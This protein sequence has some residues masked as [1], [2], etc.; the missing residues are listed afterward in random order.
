M[1][2]KDKDIMHISLLGALSQ[3]I[4]YGTTFG[5]TPLVAANLGA[6]SFQLGLLTM[7]FNLPQILFAALAGTVFVRYLGIRKT[8]LIG[9]GL[10]TVLSIGIPF[11][12]TLFTLYIVQIINGIGSAM[13]F[14]LLTGLVIKNVQSNLKNTVMGFYQS[15]YGV[16]MIIG[17]ILLGS[18]GDKWGLMTGFIIIGL[19]GLLAI[20]SLLLIDVESE[21]VKTS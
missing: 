2:I 7:L 14:P 12:P 13:T 6:D 10:N 21:A 1:V 4:T 11:V 20:L 8:L 9:F 5:F 17:P 3:L 15:I 16:G 18:V 19:L